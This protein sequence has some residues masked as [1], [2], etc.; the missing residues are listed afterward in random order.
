MRVLVTRPEH[1]AREFEQELRKRGHVPV[2]QSMLSIVLD[3]GPMLDVQDIG[4]L[5][6]TSANGV[7]AAA[8]RMT[9]RS[10]PVLAVGPATA[11]EAARA[12]FTSVKTS[13]GEGTKG[14]LDHLARHPELKGTRML[15][16]SGADV[17]GDLVAEAIRLGF[18]I[19]RQQLY[20]TVPATEL[21]QGLRRH[22]LDGTLEAATFFSP[23]TAEIFCRL[24]L[25]AGLAARMDRVT[26]CA[27]STNAAKSLETL[28]FRKVLVAQNA[29]AT[30]MLDLLDSL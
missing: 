9:T 29:T 12:G 4:L 26:A 5:V 18:A 28:T 3:E 19:S 13:P 1:D 15:H 10:I 8:H 11:I 16:V 27:I 24:A 7:R 14:I 6:F 2:T 20:R 23:R 22:L 25:D 17:A 30:A 21:D